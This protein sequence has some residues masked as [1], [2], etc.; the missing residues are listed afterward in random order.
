MECSLSL[1]LS[2]LCLSGSWVPSSAKEKDDDNLLSSIEDERGMWDLIF[3]NISNLVVYERGKE[4]KRR[5]R[6]WFASTIS[7]CCITIN[8]LIKREKGDQN[9][10]TFG[11]LRYLFGWL[12]STT[13]V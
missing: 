5:N 6:E 7:C 10:P 9:K 3:W 2:P 11:I 1:S 12:I 13:Y 4:R 8:T